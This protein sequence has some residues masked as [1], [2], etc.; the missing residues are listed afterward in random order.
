MCYPV[1]SW[2]ELTVLIAYENF[3]ARAAI[4]SQFDAEFSKLIARTQRI[5]SRRGEPFGKI[6]RLPF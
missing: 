5:R 1:V 3:R 6:S 2:F 4:N